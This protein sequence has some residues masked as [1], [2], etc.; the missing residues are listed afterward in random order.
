MVDDE[1]GPVIAVDVMRQ[2]DSDHAGTRDG[3]PTILETLSRAT[4]LSSVARAQANRHLAR[5]VISPSITGV[6]LRDF[7]RLDEAVD[8][9]RRAAEE[10]L[11]SGALDT[12]TASTARAAAPV[13]A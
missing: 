3:L 10:A 6:A 1:P 9:G 7:R 11:A 13:R 5:A 4:V 8:A 2:L 12:L